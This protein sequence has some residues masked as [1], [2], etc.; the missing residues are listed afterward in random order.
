[1][2]NSSLVHIAPIDI[3]DDDSLLNIFYLYRPLL[4]CEDKDGDTRLAGGDKG[5]IGEHWWFKL[6]H[7][8]QRWRNL[9]LGSCSYLGLCL[10][11]TNGMP[12]IDVLAYSPPLP[13]I[14]EYVYEDSDISTEDEG[15]LMLALEQR[16]RVRRIRLVV[17]V[18]N[19]QKLF[20]AIDEVFPI[21]EYLIITS[22]LTE[23]WP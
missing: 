17:S 18:Q 23:M 5:W 19:S 4:L 3:L 6:A 16:N 9:I 22:L 8:C 12:V 20:T 11:C 10:V 21:L 13:L 2:S 1:M 14:I 15:G 7:V